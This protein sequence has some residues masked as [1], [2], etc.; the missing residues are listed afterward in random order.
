MGLQSLDIKCCSIKNQQ[1][2]SKEGY[3]EVKTKPLVA[4]SGHWGLFGG[5][6]GFC[7]CWW[8]LMVLVAFDGFW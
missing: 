6:G 5:F 1:D 2:P 8:F 7:W 4:Y 3:F